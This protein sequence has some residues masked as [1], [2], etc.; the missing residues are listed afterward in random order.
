MQMIKRALGAKISPDSLN[1]RIQGVAQFVLQRD[2]RSHKVQV[3]QAAA[4][5][6]RHPTAVAFDVPAAIAPRQILET[7]PPVVPDDRSADHPQ[8]VRKAVVPHRAVV[9]LDRRGFVD[10]TAR[11][12]PF[13]AAG[14]GHRAARIQRLEHLLGVRIDHRVQQ[15]FVQRDRPGAS[16]LD[17]PRRRPGRLVELSV[18]GDG[19]FAGVCQQTKRQDVRGQQNL[20][21]GTFQSVRKLVVHK[22]HVAALDLRPRVPVL[23]V[24]LQLHVRVD[25]S[26]R[27]ILPPDFLQRRRQNL[28]ESL[29]QL[30]PAGAGFE[31]QRAARV[32]ALTRE[33]HLQLGH[34]VAREEVFHRQLPIVQTKTGLGI[35]QPERQPPV[36]DLAVR[37]LAANREPK[38]SVR[39]RIAAHV[40]GQR[41]PAFDGPQFVAAGA[42][43]VRYGLVQ[44]RRQPQSA[45]LAPQIPRATVGRDQRLE[46]Q[47]LQMI[48]G[49]GAAD[50]QRFR[51]WVGGYCGAGRIALRR[52]L[53]LQIAQRDG[54]SRGALARRQMDRRVAHDHLRSARPKLRRRPKA[55]QIPATLL[56]LAATQ[57]DASQQQFFGLRLMTLYQVLQA[58]GRDGHDFVDVHQGFDLR[59]AID[60][61]TLD[62]DPATFDQA[63]APHRHA[64]ARIMGRKSPLDL[65]SN[66][67]ANPVLQQQPAAQRR[68]PQQHAEHQ[69][70]PQPAVQTCEEPGLARLVH[71][72]MLP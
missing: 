24:E 20:A 64:I 21:A 48:G 69:Q 39:L 58:H 61:Q 28:G 18:D 43:R 5:V 42:P 22:R 57:L 50:L 53:Q 15:L 51:R 19:L 45:D 35:V 67:V 66:L 63:G 32:E 9:Q 46:L 23:P 65:Q 44:L 27:R 34:A 12:P 52:N 16:D 49:A 38:R 8:R 2:L 3:Q 1:A 33:R 36:D 62:L 14:K 7:P 41:H 25:H 71:E 11:L 30:Q 6:A 60:G 29:V 68:Q 70:P 37:Q 72:P 40:K 17:P 31:R 47:S 56:V 13:E 55:D 10:R 4:V 54:L 26:Q 59:A